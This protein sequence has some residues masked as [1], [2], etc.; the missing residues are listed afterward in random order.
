MCELEQSRLQKDVAP[1]ALQAVFLNA[2]EKMQVEIDPEH[3]NQ[4]NGV[5]VI[6]LDP[7]SPGFSNAD[8]TP[9]FDQMRVRPRNKDETVAEYRQ[10]AP[11][12]SVSF[13]PVKDGDRLR[14]GIEH[15]HLEHRLVRRLLAQFDAQGFRSRLERTAVLQTAI[16]R[17]RVVLL[18][19]LT[20]YAKG[21]NRLHSEIIPIAASVNLNGVTPLKFEG[22]TASEVYKNLQDAIQSSSRPDEMICNKYRERASTDAQSLRKIA[23]QRARKNEENVRRE[24]TENGEAQARSLKILLEQQR[25]RIL[26][27]Q[28]EVQREFDFSEPE[29]EQRRLD[30][31]NWEKRLQELDIEIETE[32]ELVRQKHIVSARRIEPVGIVYLLPETPA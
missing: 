29:R 14:T 8:W 17:P 20:L 16:E 23:E 27:Q 5:D 22:Q 25:D 18:I 21:A 32:P 31:L 30:K 12:K 26:E 4:E 13:S 19:R 24:L 7:E 1:N 3:V 6:T 2:L 10:N 11:V 15:L 28:G 9:V